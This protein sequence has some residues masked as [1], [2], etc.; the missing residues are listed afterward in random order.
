MRRLVALSLLSSALL[1]FA[2]CKTP[3]RELSE[4]LCDCVEPFDREECLRA[5]AVE[6]SNVELTDE[7]YETCEQRLTTCNI[8]PNDRGTCQLLETDEGKRACGLAR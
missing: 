6:E 2:G 8:D 7:Q 4:R 3:C 1:T 5:A